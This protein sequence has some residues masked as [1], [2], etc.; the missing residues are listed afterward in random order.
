MESGCGII[1]VIYLFLVLILFG[2]ILLKVSDKFG[3]IVIIVL[4]LVINVIVGVL[5]FF[6]LKDNEKEVLVKFD[7]EVFFVVIKMFYIWIIIIIMFCLYLVNMLFYYFMF[8][9]IE[10][11]GV[12]VVFVFVI[13]ILV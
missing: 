11:F 5:V 4:Y 13:L 10:V 9:L 2:Y 12:I 8:Y 1:N 6:K 3:F 7:K